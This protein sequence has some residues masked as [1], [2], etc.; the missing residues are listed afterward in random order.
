VVRFNTKGIS[1]VGRFIDQG[2]NGFWG[3]FPIG[4]ESGGHGYSGPIAGENPFVLASDRDFGLYIFR[5]TG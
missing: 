5:Y 1:E 2:G 4:D 3:V